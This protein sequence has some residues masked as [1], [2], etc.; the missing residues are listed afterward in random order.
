MENKHIDLTPEL[1]GLVNFNKVIGNS[2]FAVK[3]ISNSIVGAMKN[4][5]NT[6]KK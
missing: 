5:L 2:S 4:L 1:E 3:S 6:I